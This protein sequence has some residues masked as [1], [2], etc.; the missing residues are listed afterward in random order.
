MSVTVIIV[1][2]V[3]NKT[4]LLKECC[5]TTIEYEHSLTYRKSFNNTDGSVP[6]RGE[7]GGTLDLH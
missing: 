3:H 1:E 6:V 7:V 5:I 4:L 2:W